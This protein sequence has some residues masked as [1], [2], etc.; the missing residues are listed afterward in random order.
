MS[1]RPHEELRGMSTSENEYL[2]IN[3]VNPVSALM[4]L[5]SRKEAIVTPML[6]HTDQGWMIA[7]SA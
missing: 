6:C 2:R 4:R 3:Q 1:L 5:P 7:N